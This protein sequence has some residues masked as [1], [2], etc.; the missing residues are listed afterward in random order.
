ME[1]PQIIFIKKENESFDSPNF[2]QKKEYLLTQ[3][4]FFKTLFERASAQQIAT[5]AIA[6]QKGTIPYN[7]VEALEL[8]STNY[9]K[10]YQAYRNYMGSFMN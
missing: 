2:N 8:A 9:T 1:L 3:M 10:A 7:A 4:Q 5:Q 6:T